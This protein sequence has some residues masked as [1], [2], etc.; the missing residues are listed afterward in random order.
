M[1]QDHITTIKRGKKVTT[2]DPFYE[3][4]TTKEDVDT[5]IEDYEA[6]LTALE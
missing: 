2:E 6:R 1:P 4:G 5:R 3:L